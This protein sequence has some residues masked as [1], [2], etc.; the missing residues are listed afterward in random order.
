MASALELI[1]M[2]GKG[3]WG[4]LR[5]GHS[6]T[7]DALGLRCRFL[8]LA[9]GVGLRVIWRP[10]WIAYAWETALVMA[11]LPI[12]VASTYQQCGGTCVRR[13]VAQ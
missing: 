5:A 12:R 13:R 2:G 7:F 1:Q 10:L 11:H 4:S 9:R 6:A 8:G 3:A